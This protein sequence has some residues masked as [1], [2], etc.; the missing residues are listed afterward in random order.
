MAGHHPPEEYDPM[1]EDQRFVAAVREGL[2]DIET[3]RWIE[4]EDLE[5]ELAAELGWE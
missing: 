2:A 4:D 1:D 3:G 5:S